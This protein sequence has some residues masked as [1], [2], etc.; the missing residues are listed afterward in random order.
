MLLDATMIGVP[1][2]PSIAGEMFTGSNTSSTNVD[3]SSIGVLPL[4]TTLCANGAATGTHCNVRR[5]SAGVTRVQLG[6]FT[7]TAYVHLVYVYSTTMSLMFGQGDSGGNIYRPSDYRVVATI[8][9]IPT[10]QVYLCGSANFYANTF[11]TAT[12]GLVTEVSSVESELH[13][14]NPD[15][16]ARLRP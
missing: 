2:T 5:T 11:C 9:A 13:E 15:L 7:P 8:S 4:N 1:A 3:I 6:S 12:T 10:S 16:V 14:T